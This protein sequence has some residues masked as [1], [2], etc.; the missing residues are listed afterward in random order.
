MKWKWSTRDEHGRPLP[1]PN[2]LRI[3]KENDCEEFGYSI[4]GKGIN[5]YT[6]KE[7]GVMS[8]V[9]KNMVILG[10]ITMLGIQGNII[11]QTPYT[12]RIF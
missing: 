12:E 5:S 9:L 11:H 2:N 7:R 8:S 4:S 3:L 6:S 1:L 10:A